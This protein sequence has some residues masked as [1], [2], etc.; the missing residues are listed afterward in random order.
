LPDW[1]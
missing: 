1:I